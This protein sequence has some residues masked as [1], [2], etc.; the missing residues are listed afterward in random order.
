MS[1]AAAAA[2]C[3]S[4]TG[5]QRAAK[6]SVGGACPRSACFPSP[7][8]APVQRSAHT[9]R[10]PAPSALQRIAQS[11]NA[12]PADASS[13]ARFLT[14]AQS[15]SAKVRTHLQG[16][17]RFSASSPPSPPDSPVPSQSACS[18]WCTWIH[19]R[20]RPAPMGRQRPPCRCEP[21]SVQWR[22]A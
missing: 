21:R 15:G 19:A 12:R 18:S 5:A 22:S 11:Q 16:F 6:A 17:S 9:G 13:V 20:R 14:S 2:N 1:P 3:S 10:R 4:R 8:R 7:C